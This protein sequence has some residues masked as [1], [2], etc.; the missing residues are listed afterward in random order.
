MKKKKI[1]NGIVKFLCC[2]K[3]KHN[4]LLPSSFLESTTYVLI[5]VILTCFGSEA[6]SNSP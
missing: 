4:Y 3:T 2:L 5:Q 1:K 6:V